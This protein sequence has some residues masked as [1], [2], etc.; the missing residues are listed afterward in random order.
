LWPQQPRLSLASDESAGGRTCQNQRRHRRCRRR[1]ERGRPGVAVA[2]RHGD[3]GRH[4]AAGQQLQ[5]EVCDVVARKA[6][7]SKEQPIFFFKRELFSCCYVANLRAVR[8]PL[9]R[10]RT[11]FVRLAM[12]ACMHRSAYHSSNIAV[13]INRH[14]FEDRCCGWR[15]NGIRNPTCSDGENLT[16]TRRSDRFRPSKKVEHNFLRGG[17]HDG[18]VVDVQGAPPAKASRPLRCQDLSI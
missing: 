6:V 12:H 11:Q 18:Q 4:V 16:A 3:G 17:R 7:A 15:T 9:I 1:Q 13:S 10:N 14:S 2:A 5:Q 8:S